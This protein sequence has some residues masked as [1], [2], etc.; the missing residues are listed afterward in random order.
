MAAIGMRRG[1]N[2]LLG[3]L[4]T[5]MPCEKP[6]LPWLAKWDVIAGDTPKIR[7]EKWIIREQ[8]IF[9][10]PC[11][12]QA[13]GSFFDCAACAGRFRASVE[14]PPRGAWA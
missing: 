5:S 13:A 9:F 1:Q 8:L 4:T 3:T 6:P 10:T 11:S 12:I 2:D 7:R 14:T